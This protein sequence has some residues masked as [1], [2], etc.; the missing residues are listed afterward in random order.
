MRA[1]AAQTQATGRQISTALT[2][3]STL[4]KGAMGGLAGA[5]TVEMFVG[6]M[7]GAHDYADSIVDLSTRTGATTTVIQQLRYAAQMTGSSFEGADAALDKFAKNLGSA[8]KPGSGMAK[9]FAALGVTATDTDGAL[10]QTMDGISKL[11]TVTARN[12]KTVELFGKS[13]N[14]LTDLLSGGVKR[15]KELSGAAADLGLV[16]EDELLQNAGQVNDQLDKLKMIVDAKMANAFVQN[17]DSI[18]LMVD[19]LINLASAA[20]DALQALSNFNAMQTVKSEG[21]VKFLLTPIGGKSSD[22]SFG[23]PSADE[24]L[25][26]NRKALHGNHDGRSALFKAN[27]DRMNEIYNSGDRSKSARQKWAK[28][29]NENDELLA[30]EIRARNPKSQKPK[31]DDDKLPKPTSSAKAATGPTL[32]SDAEL[33]EAWARDL[34]SATNGTLSLRS[35]LALDPQKRADYEREIEGNETNER[36]ASIDRDTGTDREVREG[37]KRYT[38]AQA[39]QLRAL[40]E[41]TLKLKGDLIGREELEEIRRRELEVASSGLTNQLD[42]ASGEQALA[43][44]TSERRDIAMRLIDLQDRQER[45]ALESIVNSAAASD[46]EKQIAE[47]RLAILP[48]LKAQATEQARRDTQSPLEQYLDAIPKTAAEL[49]DQMMSF[50][51]DGLSK[52]EDGLLGVWEGTE[53]ITGAMGGLFDTVIDG[54]KRVAIQQLLIK[55][56][57]SLLFGGGD[58]GGNGILGGII[59]SA[60]KGISGARA[61]GGMTQPGAYLV[62]ERGPEIAM[63]GAPANVLTNSALR[64][65][66][67]GGSRSGGLNININGPITSNDPAMVR[68]MV[69]EGV[70]SAIPLITKQST[71]ATLKRLN[72]RSI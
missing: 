34:L 62:G 66:A 56:L 60:V 51:A 24:Y 32:K 4:A 33:Q 21:L 61:N 41:Q 71:D 6:A 28:L 3:A 30:R 12:A 31:K 59:G 54:L 14:E 44:S 45:I 26:A 52:L 29:K 25:G 65:A 18:A 64:A 72:R 7:R 38:K 2:S 57:G 16:L 11:G 47:A 69:A 67:A 37:S 46:A 35:R 58:G 10:M 36:L 1:A 48:K 22:R 55:P 19:Q 15:F 70:M 42:I 27:A 5:L 20:G 39:D 53:S 9:T 40:E 50:E 68:A 23:L 63:I 17:A 43:R 49:N 13:A 8:Q